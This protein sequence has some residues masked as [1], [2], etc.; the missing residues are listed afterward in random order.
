MVLRTALFYSSL[1]SLFQSPP[2][3]ARRKRQAHGG[4]PK[5]Q[6]HDA[7]RHHAYH[8]GYTL[9]RLH[10]AAACPAAGT[11]ASLGLSKNT[12][13]SLSNSTP[14]IL[15]RSASLRRFTKKL[16]HTRGAASM[17]A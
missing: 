3:G 12:F 15:Q 8:L 17:L 11:A 6:Q 5:R 10:C 1:P 16:S 9:Q 13:L 4:Q 7:L 14:I 2:G